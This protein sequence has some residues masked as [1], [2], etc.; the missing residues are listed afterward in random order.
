MTRDNAIKAAQFVV[1][2]VLVYAAMTWM[3][4]AIDITSFSEQSKPTCTANPVATCSLRRARTIAIV[5][6]WSASGDS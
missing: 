1:C 4:R 5:L 3:I 2:A 6:K